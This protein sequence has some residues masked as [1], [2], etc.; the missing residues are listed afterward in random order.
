MPRDASE[1]EIWW[2][3]DTGRAITAYTA[4][5]R[6]ITQCLDRETIVFYVCAAQHLGSRIS[7]KS[8]VHPSDTREPRPF[9]QR[10]E[11]FENGKRPLG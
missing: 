2:K 1:A 6:T 8:A 9:M 3:W 11:R 7:R 10:D 4:Q 5:S